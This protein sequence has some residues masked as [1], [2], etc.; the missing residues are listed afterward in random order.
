MEFVAPEF[1]SGFFFHDRNRITHADST[2]IRLA[3]A[4]AGNLNESRRRS[5]T[6]RA[7]LRRAAPQSFPLQLRLRRINTSVAVQV[8][9]DDS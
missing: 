6:F 1:P 9:A 4:W 3:T 5:A 2:D 7:E 8:D